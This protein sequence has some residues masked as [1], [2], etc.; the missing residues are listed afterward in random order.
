MFLDVTYRDAAKINNPSDVVDYASASSPSSGNEYKTL[1]LTT[2]LDMTSPIADALNTA[3]TLLGIN[4]TESSFNLME[5]D[6]TGDFV[7]LVQWANR[8]SRLV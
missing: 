5:R 4:E 6:D 8:K 2:K 7:N 1:Q 3:S